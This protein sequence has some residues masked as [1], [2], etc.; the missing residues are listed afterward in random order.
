MIATQLNLRHSIVNVFGYFLIGAF[1]WPYHNALWAFAL[2]ILLLIYHYFYFQI[3]FSQRGIG[4]N[5]FVFLNWQQLNKIQV[6][7]YILD[8][9]YLSIH[10]QK[11]KI[12][13]FS[14]T[15]GQIQEFS[16]L[17]QQYSELDVVYLHE[18]GV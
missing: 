8:K 5:R 10:H 6:E 14:L 2:L 18:L 9:A 16:Q 7:R 15:T 4:L 17:V 3:S 11:G 13:K 12:F 1:L